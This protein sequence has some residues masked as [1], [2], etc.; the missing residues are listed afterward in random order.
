MIEFKDYNIFKVEH[1]KDVSFLTSLP[2]SSQRL[3]ILSADLSNPESI[4]VFHVA[5]PVDFQVKEPEEVVDSA[6]RFFEDM[7]QFQ[8]CEESC[9]HY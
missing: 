5:T 1:R 8:D 2:G 3:Q 9:L 7:P 6:L 4:G